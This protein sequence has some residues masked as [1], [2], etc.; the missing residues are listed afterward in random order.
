ML[1]HQGDKES[2][3]IATA[4]INRA[5]EGICVV[6][7]KEPYAA[8]VQLEHVHHKIPFTHG[9][10]YFTFDGKKY[11]WKAHSALLEDATRVCLGVCDRT[12]LGGPRRKLGSIILTYEGSKMRNLVVITCLVEQ[13]RSDEVKLEVFISIKLIRTKLFR[14]LKSL[15]RNRSRN[16]K[17]SVLIVPI[18]QSRV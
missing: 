18:F 3:V 10:T 12:G 1:I 6:E 8:T 2:P 17:L 7:F 15:S 16:L 13:T 14:S 5:T 9:N 11:H 4:D